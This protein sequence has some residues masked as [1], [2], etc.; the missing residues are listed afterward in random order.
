MLSGA[1]YSAADKAF[2]FNATSS[3]ADANGPSGSDPW[4][5]IETTVPQL[6][7]AQE[8]TFSGW[9]KLDA[10]GVFQIPY[11]LGRVTRT[12]D[13]GHMHWFAVIENGTLRAAVS[14]GAHINV[15]YTNTVLVANRWYHI[16]YS[17]PSGT[18]VDKFAVKVYLD[19]VEQVSTNRTGLASAID[20]GDTGDAKLYLG[21]QESST[22]YFAG[23]VSNFKIYNAFLEA[24]E[25]RKLYNLGRTG[26][27]MVISDTAVGIGKVP[28]AQLDVR[29]TASFERVGIGTTSP[30]TSLHINTNDAMIIP[31][32]DGSQRPYTGISGMIRFNSS[33]S[34]IEYYN[35]NW[36]SLAPVSTP[37]TTRGLS[38]VLDASDAQSYPG[39][40]STWTSRVGGG[41]NGNIQGAVS[42]VSNGQSS[43]FDFPGGDADRI[44]QNSGT[45]ILYKDICIVFKVDALTNSF[46]YLVSNGGDTSLRVGSG[47]INNTSGNSGD[48]SN[49]PT[50]TTYYVNGVATTASIPITNGQWY[51]LGGESKCYSSV[52]NY[53]LGWG[54]NTRALNGQIAYIALYDTALT[55]TEQTQNYNALKARFGL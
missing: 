32:G 5:S 55:A 46:A 38:V 24:S 34:A 48:W 13:N 2:D 19:G 35:G 27:S 6:N 44:V 14:G 28:E 53:F 31:V 15:Y 29:G 21:W 1:S 11:M 45:Q 47:N 54:Y 50:G 49:G 30:V 36:I 23:Q 9:F 18:T 16:S 25:V 40:G 39:T 37:I 12:Q 26:R 22:N 10:I 3:T 7:G 41:R 42:W 33:L 8:I 43:Y 4:G 20:I 17:I 52:F 51:I